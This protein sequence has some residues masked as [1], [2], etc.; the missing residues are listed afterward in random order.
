MGQNKPVLNLILG[1]KKVW[2]K[3]F[4]IETNLGTDNPKVGGL[5]TFQRTREKRD[6]RTRRP[7]D[8]GK[9]GPC[10]QKFMGP[11]DYWTKGPGTKGSGPK[12]QDQLLL[13]L[14]LYK[15]CLPKAVSQ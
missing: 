4:F 15:P 8:Q 10:D 6:Q 9:K 2:S 14:R 13:L 3:K 12:D 5:K 7:K 11:K 1:P